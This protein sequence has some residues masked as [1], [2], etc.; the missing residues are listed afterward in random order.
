MENPIEDAALYMEI[1]LRKIEKPSRKKEK[2]EKISPQEYNL[3]MEQQK[4]AEDITKPGEDE[5]I[6]QQPITV[7]Q[8]F[9]VTQDPL[10]ILKKK[11]LYNIQPSNMVNDANEFVDALKL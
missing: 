10:A 6:I 4:E 5:E 9:K 8:I 1:L 2:V 3:F 11:A 7:S